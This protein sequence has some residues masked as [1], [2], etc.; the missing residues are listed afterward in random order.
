MQEIVFKCVQAVKIHQELIFSISTLQFVP[1]NKYKMQFNLSPYMFRNL[2]RS[3]SYHSRLEIK[4]NLF[5][6]VF[7]KKVEIGRSLTL[8]T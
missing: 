7:S 4:R 2:T 6:E 8:S 3:K 1:L 5:L